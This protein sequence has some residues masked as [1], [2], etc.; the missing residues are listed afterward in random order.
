MSVTWDEKNVNTQ[1][2]SIHEQFIVCPLPKIGNN[3]NYNNYLYIYIYNRA[4]Q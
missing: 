4:G 3:N 2:M 1:I